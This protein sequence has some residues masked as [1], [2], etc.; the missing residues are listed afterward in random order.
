MGRERIRA[1]SGGA[2]SGA[3]YPYE[4]NEAN[5]Y[6][7]SRMIDGAGPC[8]AGEAAGGHEV[9]AA[10][11]KVEV[12]PTVGG[13]HACLG[14]AGASQGERGAKITKRPRTRIIEQRDG[15][16]KHK[17]KNAV[18]RTHYRRNIP[19]KSSIMR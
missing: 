3:K 4:D 6:F 5:H 17:G 11:R 1:S 9:F 16:G 19:E 18:K 10:R 7:E 15:D 2:G 12:E 8:G 14:A 13:E